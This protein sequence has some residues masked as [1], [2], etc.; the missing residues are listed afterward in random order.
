MNAFHGHAESVSGTADAAGDAAGDT[1]ADAEGSHF[2]E[3]SA[4]DSDGAA[5]NSDYAGDSDDT[6][7][8]AV[9]NEQPG[10][11]ARDDDSKC[12]SVCFFTQPMSEKRSKVCS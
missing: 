12:G 3:G 4:E 9:A 8:A 10:T 1:D 5:D 2:D 6:A 7:T 11:S